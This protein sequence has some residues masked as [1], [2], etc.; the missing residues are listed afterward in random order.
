MTVKEL[1]EK[2]SKISESLEVRMYTS[3]DAAVGAY[4]A[5]VVGGGYSST[6]DRGYVTLYSS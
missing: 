6:E 2:L 3:G 4:E 1:I 5:N